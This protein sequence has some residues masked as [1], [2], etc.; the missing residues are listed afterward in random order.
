[1]V[2]FWGI[3]TSIQVSTALVLIA[4]FLGLLTMKKYSK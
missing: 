3:L 1:M 2:D 4:L